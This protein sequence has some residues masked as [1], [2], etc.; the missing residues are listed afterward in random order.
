MGPEIMIQT[1]RYVQQVKHGHVTK[2][3][4]LIYLGAGDI[5]KKM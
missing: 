5:C 1:V 3:Q 4:P 2:F